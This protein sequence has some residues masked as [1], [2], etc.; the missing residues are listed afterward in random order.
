M[1]PPLR[2]R[3][4][5]R[6]SKEGGMDIPATRG[7]MARAGIYLGCAGVLLA[8]LAMAL[9]HDPALDETLLAAAAAATGVGVAVLTLAFDRLPTWGAH[10]LAAVG[11][12]VASASIYAWG[13]SSLLGAL[14]YV[15][16]TIYVFYFF[17]LRYALVHLA[18]IGAA[19]AAVV[20]VEDPG[21][22]AAGD[23][24]AT[25][26]TLATAGILI[27]AARTRIREVVVNLSDAARRDALTQLLNRRGFEEVFDTELERARRSDGIFSLVLGD[28]DRFKRVN[29]ALGHA[30]G[31]AALRRVAEAM[32]DTK[33]RFDNAARVGGEEFAIL[34]PNTDEHGAYILAERTRIEI[35]QAFRLA[36]VPLTISFGVVTFPLHGQTADALLEAGD[37]A[38]YAAKRLGRNRS[39]ISSAEVPGILAR[40][41][42]GDEG[43]HVDLAMLL[44]LAEAL[45][46]RDWGN[47]AHCHRVA[48]FAEL[49]ARELGLPPGAVERL[50][51]AGMLHDV[52]RVG[53]PDEL[54]RKSGPLNDEDWAF[55]RS[56]PEVGA[57]MVETT[58]FGD[59]GSWILAHHERPDGRGYPEGLQAEEVPLE[60]SI[61]AVADAY[62][63]MT[64]DRSYRP[65]FDAEQASLELRRGA[66][67]QF[68]EAVVEAFLRV[69]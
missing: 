56:H 39:V 11:T 69:A 24:V 46:M 23:W 22:S 65:A 37:Q 54:F 61:L 41:P 27:A 2:E 14:P 9:P 52:G 6:T 15:W 7:A 58:E 13:T 33:R 1:E 31:D 67:S 59:I 38:L 28:L 18:S 12:L 17:P 55:V 21:Y 30:A 35:E 45:D 53:M 19:F 50:R 29:D 10:A 36:Q 3:I 34:A 47:A 62:E 5:W 26:G 51:I 63:A 60:A 40:A 57:R 68:D 43:E 32:R 42:L 44:T 20:A 49:T 48:R 25:M 4:S 66:G 16:V 64:S 8:L